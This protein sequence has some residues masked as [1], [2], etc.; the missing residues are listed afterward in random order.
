MKFINYDFKRLKI[1]IH[2]DI[3]YDQYALHTINSER[4]PISINTLTKLRNRLVDYEEQTGNDSL[5]EE[6][7]FV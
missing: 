3:R 4:Q 2:F 7:D 1:Y 5:K 6:V